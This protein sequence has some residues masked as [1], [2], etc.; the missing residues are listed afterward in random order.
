MLWGTEERLHELL[1]DA[2]TSL[3]V[4]KRTFMFRYRSAAHWLE[5]FSTYYGP[6]ATALQLLDIGGQQCLSQDLLNLLERHNLA[7]DGTLV[8]PG[9]YLEVVAIKR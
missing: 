1:D 5:I 9:D 3:Q 6:V 2:T 7:K 8:V 4:T